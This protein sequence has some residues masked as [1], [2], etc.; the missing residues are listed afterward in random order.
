MSRFFLNSV[1]SLAV[2]VMVFGLAGCQSAPAQE[3]VPLLGVPVTPVAQENM[4]G[5]AGGYAQLEKRV[6][7]LEGQMNAAQPTLKKVEMMET[8]FKA[9]SLEL[10]R[11]ATSY[12]SDEPA[13]VVKE[14][15][16]EAAPQKKEPV[17][18][19]VKKAEPAKSVPAG[20]L[21]VT[22][23]RVG[24]QSKNITRIVLDTT[25]PAELRYD[26]DNSEGLLVI[27]IPK[28]QWKATEEL[29]FKNSPMIK[30]FHAT[31]DD[32]GAHLA[33][34]LKQDAKVVT[35]ARL[36]PSGSSGHRVYVDIAPTK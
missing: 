21:A 11:I 24:E 20:V 5:D 17:K 7:H 23:V 18:A 33:I 10:D 31:Q 4:A 16:K 26:L 1:S 35:T 13:V 34:D 29:A 14:A 36:T 19:E 22:S 8:H 32:N 9:L 15:P 3:P 25:K 6:Q 30:A 12:P 27:D 2:L 28:S